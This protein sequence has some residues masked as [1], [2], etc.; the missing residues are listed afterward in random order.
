M[1]CSQCAQSL[2]ALQMRFLKGF[3][4]DCSRKFTI[5]SF[6]RRSRFETDVTIWF[7]RVDGAIPHHKNFADVAERP[8]E[9]RHVGLLV[10]KPPAWPGCPSMS[11]P[12]KSSPRRGTEWSS[13]NIPR[14]I[15]VEVAFRIAE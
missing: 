6:I 3:S 4:V 2:V 5:A 1:A 14:T 11:L 13:A 9:F 8:E 12:T 10:A 7:L 15:S